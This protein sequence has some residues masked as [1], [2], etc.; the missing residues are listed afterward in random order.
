MNPEPRILRG[1]SVANDRKAPLATLTPSDVSPDAKSSD[2]R[3]GGR[4]APGS[5]GHLILGSLPDLT[6]YEAFAS[7]RVAEMVLPFLDGRS[8]AKSPSG[9]PGEAI[10]IREATS[11]ARAVPKTPVSCLNDFRVPAS[12]GSPDGGNT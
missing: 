12:F 6:H 9:R 4:L 10:A 2:N 5:R 8:G 7:T 3:E 1:V 11:D